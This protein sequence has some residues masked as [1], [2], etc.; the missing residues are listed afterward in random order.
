MCVYGKN[1]VHG[2]VMPFEIPQTMLTNNIK[3]NKN[4][5]AYIFV[6][7]SVMVHI[8]RYAFPQIVIIN[9]RDVQ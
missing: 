4:E 5:G 6:F 8:R 2:K 3:L 9:T 7:F 1:E